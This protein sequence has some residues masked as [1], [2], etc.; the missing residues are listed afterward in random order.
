M[1]DQPSP[2]QKIL[3]LVHFLNVAQYIIYHINILVFR[4]PGQFNHH[5]RFAKRLYWTQRLLVETWLIHHLRQN[6]GCC[7]V[8]W[9][10]KPSPV[11]PLKNIIC[12]YAITSFCKTISVSTRKYCIGQCILYSRNTITWTAKYGIVGWLCCLPVIAINITVKITVTFICNYFLDEN[13]SPVRTPIRRKWHWV[14]KGPEDLYH[15]FEG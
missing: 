14:I 2:S 8:G 1:N 10:V 5:H 6:G 7:I 15:S 9:N 11:P 4:L 12:I 3:L 13:Y